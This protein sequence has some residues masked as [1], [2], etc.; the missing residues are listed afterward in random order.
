MTPRELRATLDCLDLSAAEGGHL[1]GVHE[2]RRMGVEDLDQLGEIGERSG[3]AGRPC[4]LLDEP[5]D[6]R[7]DS[8]NVR[9]SHYC[10]RR[11]ARAR[12]PPHAAINPGNPAPTIGPGTGPTELQFVPGVPPPMESGV[13]AFSRENHADPQVVPFE[14]AKP[15]LAK[16]TV[17]SLILLVKFVNVTPALS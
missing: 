6:I 15:G 1:L 14:G 9:K 8:N 4:R 13:S 10:T 3:S 12:R 2:G 16:L 7:P 17:T 5:K 11:R